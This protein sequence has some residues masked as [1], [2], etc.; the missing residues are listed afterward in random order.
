MIKN[1]A[2][3]DDKSYTQYFLTLKQLRY[4]RSNL[5]FRNRLSRELSIAQTH[6]CPICGEDLYN[7]ETLHKHHI[8]P[9][10]EGGK[11]NFSNLVILHQPC[12]A[13]ITFTKSEEEKSQI[14]SFLLDYKKKHPSLLA[15]FLR[16]QRSMGLSSDQIT[17]HDISE[18]ESSSIIV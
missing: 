11:T 7:G 10:K 3:P 2:L 14:E 5:F 9:F 1:R 16:S 15:R 17:E 4:N 18:F 12:H 8:I 13:K 6:I